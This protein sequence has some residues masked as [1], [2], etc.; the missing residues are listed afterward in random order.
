MKKFEVGLLIA[1]A[2]GVVLIV[3]FGRVTGK[4]IGDSENEC[5]IA[6]INGDGIVNYYDKVDFGELY[7]K[8]YS[9]TNCSFA[10]V[11]LDKRLNLEDS[12]YFTVLYNS[13]YG[14]ET[15]GCVKRKLNCETLVVLDVTTQGELAEEKTGIF[16][17]IAEFFKGLF[18]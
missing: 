15:G 8:D 4:V 17:K 5:D 3:L 18:N 7:D 12:D 9:K 13:N 1:L 14:I 16:L 6:D 2:F 10:D 11:N